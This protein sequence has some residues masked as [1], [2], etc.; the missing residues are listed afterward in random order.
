MPGPHLEMIGQRLEPG[1]APPELARAGLGG[2]GDPGRFLEQVGAA[3][4]A[5][6]D[7]VAGDDPDRL[8]G[9]RAIGHQKTEMLG[10]VARG[11]NRGERDVADGNHVV[12]VEERHLRVR[13]EAVLPLGG[14]AAAEIHPRPGGGRQ[15]AEPGDEIGVNVGLGD[16]FDPELFCGGGREIGSHLAGRVEHDGAPGRLTSDQ[17]ARLGKSVVVEPLEEHGA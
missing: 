16:R 9:G 11:V 15:L 5:D 12:I 1:E 8:I 14:A 10:G 4:V 3:D 6:E 17:V 2:V 7:E 13:P